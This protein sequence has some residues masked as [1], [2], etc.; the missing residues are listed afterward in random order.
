MCTKR[1]AVTFKWQRSEVRSRAEVNVLFVLE[2]AW[3]RRSATLE[4]PHD[5]L[6]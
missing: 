4:L 1:G 6:L 3:R 5:V 2:L